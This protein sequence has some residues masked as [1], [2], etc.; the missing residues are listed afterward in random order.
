MLF[1]SAKVE[2]KFLETLKNIESANGEGVYKL[3]RLATLK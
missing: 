2:K 3:D 1:Q